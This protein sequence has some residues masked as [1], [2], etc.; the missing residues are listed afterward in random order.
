MHATIIGGLTRGEEIQ[1]GIGVAAPTVAVLGTIVTIII[2]VSKC[3]S[4]RVARTEHNFMQIR[5]RLHLQQ[6]PCTCCI[7]SILFC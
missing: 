6:P 5:K 4:H 7:L 3:C 1:V 2:A